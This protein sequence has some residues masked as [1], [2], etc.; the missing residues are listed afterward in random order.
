MTTAEMIRKAKIEKV[1]RI[2]QEQY[3]RD[4]MLWLKEMLG[5]DSKA[6]RWSEY[7]EGYKTHAWDGDIDPMFN[8]WNDLA[9][10][11][12]V[13][14]DGGIPDFRIVGME[15]ATGCHAKG[16][17]VIMFDGSTKA[18]ED[19]VVGDLLMGDDSTPRRVLELYRGQETMYRI[20]PVNGTPFV[21]NASHI[22]SLRLTGDGY[23]GKQ[24]IV[25]ISVKEY[26]QQ[27]K[28]FKHLYK[29]YRVPVA[30]MKKQLPHEPYFLGLWIG[31]GCVT[32]C[33]I[34]KPDAEIKAYLEYYAAKL[35]GTLSTYESEGKCPAYHIKGVIENGKN[36]VKSYLQSTIVDSEKR[37][38]FEYLT[39]DRADR[40]E[41]LAGLLDT[42][43]SKENSG[44]EFST[45]Y[46]GLA[47]DVAYLCRGLG[48]YC[49]TA[50]KVV[51][52]TVY[53]RLGVY[54]DCTDIP[55]RIERK[56]P[57][58]R[59]QRKNV[60][61]TG[62]TVEELPAD[63]YYGFELDNNHLYLLDDCMVT[64]N[65]GKTYMLA[66]IV[67]WFLSSFPDSL[68]ITTA[69]LATQLKLGV[70]SEV[71]KLMGRVKRSFPKSNLYKLNLRMNDVN[72]NIKSKT[73][74]TNYDNAF[75]GWQATSFV[76][77]AGAEEASAVKAR[78]L[79]RKY[80]LIILEEASGMNAA[81]V[82]AF[83]NTCTGQYNYIFALG[84]PNNKS[85]ALNRLVAQPNTRHYRVSAYDHPNIVLGR[86]E[87][88]GAVTEASIIDRKSV[89]GEH[90]R[91]YD[92]M[93][94]GIC[95]EQAYNSLIHHTWLDAALNAEVDKDSTENA[96]G[97]DVAASENGDKGAVAYG[98]ANRLIY[99]KEF[100]CPNATYLSDNLLF[101]KG[102]LE[103]KQIRWYGIPSM[104]E[105]G[106]HS[107]YVGIDSVGVGTATVEGFTNRGYDVQALSGGAWQEVIPTDSFKDQP[108]WKFNNLRSQMYYELR[109][110]L[111]LGKIGI[112]L[113]DKEL[114]HSLRRELL[115]INFDNSNST[116]SI[117]AKE[118]IKKKLGGKSPN[119]ADAVVYWNWVRKGYRVDTRV[120]LP[121][122]AGKWEG[123]K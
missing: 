13:A 55:M 109:E 47:N 7:G 43:G 83:Q 64:H 49:H 11:Y 101:D 120:A 53:Y 44:Y 93:V 41:L 107:E 58:P 28:H 50:E 112:Y 52:G 8:A 24:Q 38:P 119:M 123:R 10:S 5:E 86:E 110:D 9:K 15:A 90:S 14:A 78:G 106:V 61:N 99:I 54:G 6:F 111:R 96:A 2:K 16:Q 77:Q 40:L 73:E 21:V 17:K 62:F 97:V 89:Y 69:P 79:H 35:G 104:G 117:E 33:T 30:F 115:S 48:L 66:R 56:K 88:F 92:A 22:L 80:M 72:T 85:D 76:V 29:L 63:D 42:D 82:N 23:R 100:A 1:R 102:T 95:P 27:N 51:N 114:Y 19:V 87:I 65:T 84:N 113:E 67:Y 94:R 32:S 121:I 4:P 71:S 26:L 59:L 20:V 118:A 74:D 60:L 91:L 25:N 81:V 46:K 116:I 98:N 39:S 12:A 18:V 75:D 36:I 68:V 70:W 37:I 45:K 122:S 57:Q 3:R 103:N 105:M 108:M 34:T 31:D